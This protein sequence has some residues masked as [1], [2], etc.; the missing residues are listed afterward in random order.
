[1][2]RYSG[3]RRALMTWPDADASVMVRI[4]RAIGSQSTERLSLR[5]RAEGLA[6]GTWPVKPGVLQLP[7]QPGPG[8]S[9]EPGRDRHSQQHA[10]QVRG[11]L[12]G[13]VPVPGQRH[14]R[15]VD[16]RPVADRARVQPG[17]GVRD[18]HLPAARALQRR[19]SQSVMSLP[20]VTSQDCA[21]DAPALSAPSKAVPHREHCAGE[22]ASL[23]WS[24]SGSRRARPRM[25]GCRH[26]CGPCGARAPRTGAP[27]AL[28]WGVP[29]PPMG[30]FEVGARVGAVHPQ[31]ALQLGDPQ[32]QPAF[33][34]Q[35][36]GQLR[37]Q[38]GVLGVPCLDHRAQPGQQLTLLPA[39]R[40]GTPGT[41]PIILNLNYRFKAPARR[42]ALRTGTESAAISTPPPATPHC[43]RRRHRRSGRLT[44]LPIPKAALRHGLIPP[45]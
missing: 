1:M 45:P 8:L 3:T 18:S 35:R 26:A 21:H 30:S 5:W 7:V 37:A 28:P 2:R 14:R 36:R 38:P 25:T 19:S 43:A 32:L 20:I 23:R 24:G 15:R 31:Q 17:R 39:E 34:L 27:S 10:D 41:S 16:P 29:A 33:P 9:N 4:D 42:R 44:R 11:P 40:S 22:S 6:L 12:G 13:H